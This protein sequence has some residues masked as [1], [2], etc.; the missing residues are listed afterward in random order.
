MGLSKL[1]SYH[2]SSHKPVTSGSDSHLSSAD[3]PIELSLEIE[4]PPCVLYGSPTESS[5]CLLSGLLTLNIKDPYETEQKADLLTPVVSKESKRKSTLQSTLSTT[6]S[7]LSINSPTVSPVQSSTN[8]KIMGG[9]TKVTI[10]KVSLTLVQ[11]VQY[12]KPF[13]PDLPSV[14][15]CMNCKCM[16]KDMKSWDIENA[17][18]DLNVGKHS[19]P[20]SYLIPGNTPATAFLGSNSGTHIEYELVAVATYKDPRRGCSSHLKDQLLQLSMPIRITRSTPRTPDKTSLR[21]FPPTELTATAVLPNVI[22]PK[23]TF[24][25]EMK[26]DGISSVDRRWRMRKLGWRI[27]EVTRVRSHVCDMHIHE[28]KNLE[29]TVEAK[30]AKSSKKSTRAKGYGDAGPL[31][32]LSV[33]SAEN[34]PLRQLSSNPER[35]AASQ[36]QE[37]TENDPN[38]DDNDFIHPS[39]YA[40]RQEIQTQQQHLM[41]RQIDEELKNTIKLFTEENRI[42]ARGEM[43]SGWKSDFDNHGQVELIT[44]IDCMSLNSGVTNPLT[45]ATTETPPLDAI[46]QNINVA[47]DIQDPTLGIYVTHILVVE[48]VVAEE[49]LQYANGQPIKKTSGSSTEHSSGKS[50]SSSP[51]QSGVDQRLA[52]LSPMLANRNTAR[53]RPAFSD[54]LTPTNSR[55]SAKSNGSGKQL[56]GNRGSRII[57]VPTGSA[58]VL[59]MQFRLNFTERSGLG[60]SWDEEVPPIYQDV[61]LLSPP[62]YENSITKTSISAISLPEYGSSAEQH[63]DNYATIS[64]QIIPPPAAHYHNSSSSLRGLTAVHSP[65]LDSVISIQGNVP[66]HDNVLTPHATRDIGIRSV[67][68]LLDTDRITQ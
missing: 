28:L 40:L 8:L 56:S 1:V 15:A 68:E 47:C 66:Y 13:L 16:T 26:I 63:Q 57:S 27:E 12:G 22:Y 19:F 29:K 6:F 39:D 41:Q 43:K 45:R 24:P 25:L 59:R 31:V 34:N 14:Q 32:R 3:R 9:Y 60:I 53:V 23:S 44:D 42:I 65:T 61:Q 67:S 5:G 17:S 49:S 46:K 37:D 10:T 30:E 2:S 58:R 33:T 51:V 64:S 4:S 7:H 35:N 54:D 50:G 38:E 55:S 52:E 48:V 11:K 36:A 21:V 62:S 18:T 20:F